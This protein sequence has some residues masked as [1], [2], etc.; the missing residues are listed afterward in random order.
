MI[1]ANKAET[2]RILREVNM[3]VSSFMRYGFR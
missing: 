3:L 1:V 2:V